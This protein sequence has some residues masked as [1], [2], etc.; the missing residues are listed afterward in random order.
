M[1]NLQ[2]EQWHSNWGSSWS[3]KLE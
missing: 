1:P 3:R 2:V